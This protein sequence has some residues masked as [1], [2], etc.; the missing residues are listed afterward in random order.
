[1]IRTMRALET[2]AAITGMQGAALQNVLAFY[3]ESLDDLPEDRVVAA[4]E[5]VAR[6]ARRWPTVDDIREAAG[7]GAQ[8]PAGVARE[9]ADKIV[10][11][12]RRYG[13]MAGPSRLPALQEFLGE[14]AW[15]LVQKLG[16]WNMLCETVRDDQLPTL[17]AQWRESALALIDRV[18]RG[19][20]LDAPPAVPTL[21]AAQRRAVGG[22]KL[23]KE[24]MP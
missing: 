3:A 14:L 10:E 22:L 17:K 7:D 21:P 1:M 24:L 15:A 11:G 4:I 20:A 8:D 16:G 23:V 18:Q 13:Y 2:L 19:E 5:Q 6:K 9:V 12:I